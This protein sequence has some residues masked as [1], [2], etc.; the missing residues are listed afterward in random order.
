ML[1]SLGVIFQNKYKQEV[2]PMAIKPYFGFNHFWPTRPLCKCVCMSAVQVILGHSSVATHLK[3]GS[4]RILG[5]MTGYTTLTHQRAP[6]IHLST[7]PEQTPCLQGKRFNPRSL[8]GLN[9]VFKA[10]KGGGTFRA[11]SQGEAS[12]SSRGMALPAEGIFFDYISF[13]ILRTFQRT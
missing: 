2:E 7:F 4:H 11:P 9:L 8:A 12:H 6:G 1:S 5:L 3:T 13:G 10:Q